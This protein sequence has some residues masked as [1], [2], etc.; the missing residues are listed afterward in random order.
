[1]ARYGTR[2]TRV[3]KNLAGGRTIKTRAGRNNIKLHIPGKRHSYT[4]NFASAGQGRK[5]LV[6]GGRN[7]TAALGTNIRSRT[8]KR[9]GTA[10]RTLALAGLMSH[11]RR[12]RYAAERKSNAVFSTRDVPPVRAQPIITKQDRIVRDPNRG[13]L[14]A[15]RPASRARRTRRDSKGRYA[16]SY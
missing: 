14:S 11:P 7:Y 9:L 13:A 2:T 1:M 12:N 8:E 4:R 6:R 3:A 10:G 15:P 5:L 16:G